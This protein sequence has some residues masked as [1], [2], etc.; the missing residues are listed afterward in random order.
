MLTLET[1][2]S[3]IDAVDDQLLALLNERMQLVQSVGEL[4]RSTHTL[5]YRPEREKSIVERLAVQSGGPLEKA[6]IAAIF[7]EIFA[8]A[9]NI[10]LPE[11]VAYLGPEG[12][13]C[14]LYTSPSPRD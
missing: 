12:S 13:F 3:R 9:R 1:L 8:V 11:R 4:K 7:Q 14:L 2:R 10:E 6:S 5:I